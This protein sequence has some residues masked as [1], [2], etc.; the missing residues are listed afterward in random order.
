MD[1]APAKRSHD[2]RPNSQRNTKIV[3]SNKCVRKLK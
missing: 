2:T 1:Q 3:R